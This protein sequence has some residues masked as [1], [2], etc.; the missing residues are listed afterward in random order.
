MGTG[1]SLTNVVKRKR[2]RYT[3]IFSKKKKKYTTKCEDIGYKFIPFTFSTFGELGEDALDSLS[4]IASFSLSN[5][6]S[7]KYR[8]YI[9]FTY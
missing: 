2:K 3:T 8:A 6:S 4:K 1:A 9:I 5:S 7:T